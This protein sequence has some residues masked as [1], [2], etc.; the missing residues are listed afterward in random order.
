MNNRRDFLKKVGVVTSLSAMGLP[1]FAFSSEPIES[2]TSENQKN[3]SQKVKVSIYQT[4][5][6]HCQVHAHDEL[7][8]ENN[9]VVFRK[10]G[11]YAYLKTLFDKLKQQNPNSFFIDTGDLFQGSELSV[12][13]TGK[14]LV[15]L[16]NALRY[17]LYLP[18][19]WEFVFG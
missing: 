6:V 1:S 5:D 4:T 18:G 12:K 16:L 15:P 11:G 19:N 9:Q 7:F 8:W 13:P 17:H 3:S 10:T 2:N 14:A